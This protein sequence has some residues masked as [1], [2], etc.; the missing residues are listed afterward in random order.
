MTKFLII[1]NK[2]PTLHRIGNRAGRKNRKYR[3]TKDCFP[4]ESVEN[5]KIRI[6]QNNDNNQ[7]LCK[8]QFRSSF[9]FF[10][11]SGIN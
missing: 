5:N 10:A 3:K 7:T 4:K 8:I 1:E 9:S 11:P 2:N 6:E